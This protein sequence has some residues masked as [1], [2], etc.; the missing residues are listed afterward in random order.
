MEGPSQH[1]VGHLCTVVDT[2]GCPQDNFQRTHTNFSLYK[3]TFRAFD[4][5]GKGTG[6]MNERKILRRLSQSPYRLNLYQV[7]MERA[8]LQTADYVEKH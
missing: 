4:T 1:S 3:C 8:V 6:K 2:S 5:G 7:L